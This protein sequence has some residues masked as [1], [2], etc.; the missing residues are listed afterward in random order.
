MLGYCTHERF[1]EHVTSPHH[2]ERPER[3]GAIWQAV[4]GA[5][6]LETSGV[7]QLT[8]DAP[9]DLKWLE[10]VHSPRHIEH[11]R[12]VCEIGG[13]VLDLGDTPVCPVSYDVALLGVGALL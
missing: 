6:L 1:I 9:A 10:L 11:V 4:A 2:P 12:H 8:V 5:R 3:I 13:G 7:K